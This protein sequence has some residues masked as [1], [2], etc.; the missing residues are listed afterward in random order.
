MLYHVAPFVSHG[1]FS[2]GMI[3]LHVCLHMY[4]ET[5]SHAHAYARTLHGHVHIHAYMHV[6]DYHQT[7]LMFKPAVYPCC[8]N[9][10][11]GTTTHIHE[12]A[13]LSYRR[14]ATFFMKFLRHYMSDTF[15]ELSEGIM[16]FHDSVAVW[17][18]VVDAMHHKK[19]ELRQ[20]QY[21]LISSR[22]S[23]NSRNRSNNDRV[24][25]V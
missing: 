13:E 20:F 12:D 4:I 17:G 9:N 3:S 18:G 10:K 22:C 6:S 19:T 2:R 1:V 16:Y 21:M 25:N 11:R 7:S 14:Y 24:R 15:L 23:R 5:Y 8:G